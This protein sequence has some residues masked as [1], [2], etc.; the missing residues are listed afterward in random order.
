RA[1]ALRQ[2]LVKEHPTTPLYRR[3]LARSHFQL[4]ELHHFARRWREAA[5]V[6]PLALAIYEQLAREFPE[7]P[8]QPRAAA[9]T[10]AYLGLTA[11]QQDRP[12]EAEQHHRRALEIRQKLVKDHPKEARYRGDLLKSCTQLFNLLGRSNPDEATR[13]ARL[14][15]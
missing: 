14:G 9:D 4:G 12:A 11:E 2:Q 5:E 6:F 8:E 13:F 15:L 10:L 1:R 7:D 3:D